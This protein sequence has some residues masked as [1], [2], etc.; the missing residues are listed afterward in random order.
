LGRAQRWAQRKKGFVA[1][2]SAFNKDQDKKNQGGVTRW[3]MNNANPGLEIKQ[4]TFHK[5]FVPR[6]SAAGVFISNISLLRKE[7]TPVDGSG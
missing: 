6:R 4:S 5:G 2:C 7:A 1:P 3:I